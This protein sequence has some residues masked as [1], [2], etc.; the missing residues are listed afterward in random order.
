V[1]GDVV[2]EPVP[3]FADARELAQAEAARRAS[4]ER[5]ILLART[6]PALLFTANPD[7]GWD[8]VNPSFSAY[9]GL[10]EDEALGGGWVSSVHPQDVNPSF[11]AWRRATMM[12]APFERD[13][14]LLGRDGEFRWFN[15]QAK[16]LLNSDG[17]VSRWFGCFTKVHERHLAEERQ[18]H[19]S[20]ELQH[21]VRNILSMI[22][23]IARG[24]AESVTSVDEF[25]AHFDGRIE[26]LLRAQNMLM[27]TADAGVDLHELVTEEI[28]SQAAGDEERILIQGDTVRLDRRAAE[29]MGLAVHE[30]ATNAAKFGVLSQ[31]IGNLLISWGIV[32]RNGQTLAFEWRETGVPI[33]AEPEKRGF[34]CEIIQKG[35]VYELQA[36]TSLQFTSDGVHCAIELPLLSQ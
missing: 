36:V 33:L 35:L 22:R 24:T 17:R 20:G 14:R 23:S 6:V 18:A 16:P 26:A 3:A 7:L 4:E 9:T 27:R 13:L 32:E 19:L 1:S 15:M 8:Y 30:L 31:Q 11:S 29:L 21:R 28:F 25:S 2:H 34:G 10:G 5:F 12:G